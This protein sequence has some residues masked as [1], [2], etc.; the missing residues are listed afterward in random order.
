MFFFAGKVSLCLSM[1]SGMMIQQQCNVLC[2]PIKEPL[3]TQ[4][5][6]IYVVEIDVIKVAISQHLLTEISLHMQS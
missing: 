5:K 6:R 3:D 4:S 2:L 1:E